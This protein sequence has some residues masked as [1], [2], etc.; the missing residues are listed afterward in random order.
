MAGGNFFYDISRNALYAK[1]TASR[2]VKPSATGWAAII[3]VSPKYFRPKYSASA[4]MNP[5]REAERVVARTV[6]RVFWRNMF[7]IVTKLT[8][9]Y[10]MHS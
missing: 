5:W 4:S 2:N 1:G 7:D 9:Q 8:D 6:R 10:T 3:P